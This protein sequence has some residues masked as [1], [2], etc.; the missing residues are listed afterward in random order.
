MGESCCGG[1]D[2]ESSE[3]HVHALPQ[4]SHKTLIPLSEDHHEEKTSP[5]EYGKLAFVFVGIAVISLLSFLLFDGK[6]PYRDLSNIEA[7]SAQFMGVFFLVFAAF[8]LVNLT[9][10]VHGFMMYDL[11]AA[12]SSAYARVYPFLQLLLGIAMFVFPAAPIVHAGAA[13]LSG[14]A[15]I[16]VINS[17]RSKREIQCACLG[18]VIRMPLAHVSAVEDGL[19]FVLAIYMFVAMLQG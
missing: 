2:H 8:K 17:L 9:S 1:H 14:I 18:N 3:V 7:L 19:M 4:K 12:R 10:F 13:V 16:G 11:I 15:L 6:G 5:K